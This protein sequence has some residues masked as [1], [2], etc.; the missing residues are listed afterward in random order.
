VIGPPRPTPPPT[1]EYLGFRNGLGRRE[2]LLMQRYPAGP[3]DYT[4][5]IPDSAF[6][7]RQV[8]LQDGPAVCYEKLLGV[9]AAAEPTAERCFEVTAD[10]LLAY[11]TAHTPVKRQSFASKQA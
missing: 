4:V 10:E 6:A 2:Y 3:R 7:A 11:R 9:L 8:L 5:W 1:L